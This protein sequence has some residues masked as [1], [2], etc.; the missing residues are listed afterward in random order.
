M[1]RFLFDTNVFVYALGGPSPYREPCRAIV[2]HAAA[3]RIRGEAS[4]D[5]VREFV[6]QRMRQIGDRALAVAAA[7]RVVALCRLHDVRA[8]DLT[9]ALWLFETHERITA[10]DATFAAVA[11][12][13]GLDAILSADR[14]FDEV[15]GIE[16]IDPR[17]AGRVATL[18]G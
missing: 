10:R 1:R 9:L 15:P 16:R 13:R 17:D 11:L 2:E 7:R 5:L 14:D 3:G 4:A 12:N 6:H 18:T 8:T